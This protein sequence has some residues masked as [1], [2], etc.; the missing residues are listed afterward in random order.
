MACTGP[1]FVAGWI[2][3]NRNGTFDVG[4]RSSTVEC[5]GTV[6]TTVN[7]NWSVPADTVSSL[8]TNLSF[9][10]LRIARDAAQV[11]LPTGTSTSGEVEDHKLNI[12]LPKLALTKTSNA[13]VNSR[14]GDKITW[15]VKATNAGK[16][17]FTA[18]Y[19]ARLLDDLTGVL[20]DATYDNNATA[21]R[22][23]TLSYTSPR[24]SWIGALNVDQSV[25]LTYSATLKSGGDGTARNVAWEPKD[26]KMPSTPACNA[27][28]GGIDAATGEPCAEAKVLLPKLSVTKTASLTALPQKGNKVTYTV[29]VKNSGPGAY[30][31]LK[32]AT[33]TD[34][35]TEVLDAATFD[36]NASATVGAVTLAA[37][38]LSW[39]GALTAGQS[40]VITYTVT[41]TAGGDQSLVNRVCVPV[42]EQL[43]GG[44]AGCDTV[45]ILGANLSTSKTVTTPDTPA[46]TGS[47]LTY[48]L[49]FENRGKS[50]ATVDH[51]DILTGVVDDAT[52][53]P[54][55]S[56]PGLAATRV[57]DRIR[58]TGSIPVNGTGTVTYTATV[59]PERE[60]GD[61]VSANFLVL[62]GVQPPNECAAGDLN[63][64]STPLLNV[65]ATKSANP[66]TG[67][68]VIAGQDVT[69]TLVFSNTGKTTGAVD[70]TDDLADVVDDA[71]LGLVSV[72]PTGALTANVSPNG[73]VRIVGSLIPSQAVTVSYTVQVK[74]DGERG[75]TNAGAGSQK[76]LL[77][78]VLAPT[79]TENPE[80]GMG[81]VVCTENPVSSW[82]L[83]KAAAPASG[84]YVIPRDVLTYTVTATSVQG[85]V[86]G[87][88]LTD[89]LSDVLDNATFV[90][91]SA[92]VVIDGG[93]A[94][95][96]P[97]PNGQTLTTGPITIPSGKNVVL[98][99]RVKVGANAW[100]Q[101]LRNGI[102]GTASA[103]GAPGTQFP[104]NSCFDGDDNENCATSHP[105]SAHLFITKW[106]TT[107]DISSGP[108]A[109]SVFEVRVDDRGA[110]GTVSGTVTAVRGE[111]GRFEAAAF[112]PGSYWLVETKAPARHT[113]LAEP[114]SFM[115]A[116]DGAL[117]L[118]DGNPQAILD[119]DDAANPTIRIT[120]VAAI[121][122]PRAGGAAV[123]FVV[124]AMVMLGIGAFG[125]VLIRRQR[126]QA[127]TPAG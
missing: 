104:P 11:M 28:I 97:D 33:A 12:A 86:P 87:A 50:S 126:P 60:R 70:F 58:I 106:G 4:E 35:L 78:N 77:S 112:T 101:T 115:I 47:V 21:T 114:V 39:S 14:P 96:A 90:P 103:P 67:S 72:A 85:I 53:A 16:T 91:G 119:P 93:A 65:T 3:W 25:E 42:S 36:N 64:T 38:K 98:T 121:P 110:P 32:P 56:S 26:P 81:L 40:A 55:T 46:K 22:P 82:T 111:T 6:T 20:D 66:A 120:D 116:P 34:D 99:Y 41:Y 95:P 62:S 75:G 89:D 83:V 69:Y 27:P 125:V 108:V 109:G 61:N 18:A 63:C 51:D 44:Q 74:P 9:M 52:V 73:A 59:K 45:T 54:P 30:T 122:L 113:L 37:R 15:T 43:T 5:S 100:S 94:V 102:V 23:G 124:L 24:L 1:G 88:V 84:E 57:G 48:T 117:T 17:N 80:C 92:Q 49:R 76:D 10:R 105:V 13:T 71:A 127:P 123:N 19:P 29:T 79:G 7:L 118:A 8:G 31:A 68:A 107:G 2:D